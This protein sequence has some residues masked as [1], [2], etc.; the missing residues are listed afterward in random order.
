MQ[1][2]RHTPVRKLALILVLATTPSLVLASQTRGRALTAY[3]SL[4]LSFEVADE[5]FLARGDGYAVLLRPSGS[6]LYLRHSEL[7]MEI[8]GADSRASVIGEP[9]PGKVNYFIG[10]DPRQWRTDVSRFARLRYTGIYPGIDI[11]YYGNRRRLEYDFIVAPG[12]RPETIKLRFDGAE[13]V[14]RDS[15]GDL[16]V[17]TANDEIRLHRPYAYQHTGR[18]RR[19]VESR[20]RVTARHQVVFEIGEYDRRRELVID[21]VLGYSTFLGGTGSD[22]GNAIAVDAFGNAYVTG[23]TASTNFPTTSGAFRTTKIG[24]FGDDV[25]IT[26]L[27]SKGALVYSTYLGGDSSDSATAIAVDK[28]GNVYVTGFTTS[29]NFPVT[30]G[31]LKTTFSDDRSF[32]T[33]LN[34]AGNALVYSTY[35]AG[36]SI[37]GARAIAV[38][39]A[40]NAYVTGLAVSGFTTTPGVF[41]P[42]RKSNDAFIGKLNPAGSAWVYASFLGG[43]GFQ[44]EGFGIAADSAGNTYVTGK[45]DSTDFPVTAG[46]FTSTA[47]GGHDAFVAS[48]NALGTALRYATYLGGSGEDRGNAIAVDSAGNAYV[49]GYTY[50]QNFPT[51][52]AV[53]PSCGC[54]SSVGGSVQ[55]DAFVTKVAASGTAILYSTFYGGIGPDSG[56][57]IGVDAAG[58][59]YFAGATNGISPS[60]FPLLDSLKPT[61]GLLGDAFA[62]RL[63]ADGSAKVYSTFFGGQTTDF[64]AG[65]AVD[66]YGNLYLTGNTNSSDMTTTVGA[67]QRTYGGGNDDAFVA[68]IGDA[69]IPPPPGPRK[70]AV[71]H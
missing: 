15:N 39:S 69:A 7:Q 62:V 48:V 42:T 11:V 21:P 24:T 46:A 63:T 34:P 71:R 32:I 61:K 37:N 31:A 67:A 35:L 53:Q 38:D 30:P 19:E 60:T 49:T 17:K 44:D 16:L 56:T 1:L 70:R 50:T 68:K 29:G 64:G 47:P 41:Q 55:S 4:P 9:L 18:S 28:T 20:Y 52:A 57:G 45:T 33:K 66:P 25:F 51:M 59:I 10:G 54:Q 3:R 58:N 26:K 12:A 23:K 2:A 40:G 8:V 6:V 5:A 65:M 36:T 27:D 22:L 43:T 14:H 13:S